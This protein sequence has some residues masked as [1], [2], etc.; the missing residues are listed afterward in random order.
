[1]TVESLEGRTLRL[2]GAP[3]CGCEVDDEYRAAWRGFKLI[4]ADLCARHAEGY[5]C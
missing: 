3:W 4:H 1:V 5:G 2:R